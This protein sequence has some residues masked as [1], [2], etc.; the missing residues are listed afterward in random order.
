MPRFPLFSLALNCA[1]LAGLSCCGSLGNSGYLYQTAGAANDHI[2][3]VAK[4]PV[5]FGYERLQAL[6][7]R[8]PDLAAFIQQQGLPRYYAETKNSGDSYFILYYPKNRQAFAC[9]SMPNSAQ[10]VE[11]SG[12]YP[13]T[14][15]ELATLRKLEVGT[16]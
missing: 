9:R 13:I 16:G 8:H 3:L 7:I 10:K 14:H 2:M 15:N 1:M 6:S 12:P 4:N 11:F 5:T